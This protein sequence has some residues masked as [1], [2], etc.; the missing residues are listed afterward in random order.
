V[1]A[2]A[3]L[4]GAGLVDD[5]PD[6][7]IALIPR[8]K[9]SFLFAIGRNDDARAPGDKDALKRPPPPGGRRGGGL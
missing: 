6:G 3:S 7:V 2:C 8:T 4:H 1:K 5:K 9:A